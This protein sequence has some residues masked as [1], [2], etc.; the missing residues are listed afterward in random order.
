MEK[1]KFNIPRKDLEYHAEMLSKVSGKT[2][3]PEELMEKIER[4]ADVVK[5]DTPPADSD[6][7]GLW[8]LSRL[9]MGK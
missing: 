6:S 3:T 5:S 4:A 8:M 7:M 9:F 2:V 1:K